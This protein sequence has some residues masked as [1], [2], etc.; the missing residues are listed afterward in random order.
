MHRNDGGPYTSP[1]NDTKILTNGDFG[2]LSSSIALDREFSSMV[3]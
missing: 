2:R 1:E 3:S